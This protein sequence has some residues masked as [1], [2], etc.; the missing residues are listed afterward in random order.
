MFATLISLVI[1]PC[2]YLVLEDGK[3][4]LRRLYGRR[5]AGGAT[6]PAAGGSPTGAR[7]SPGGE[8]R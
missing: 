2:V 7:T 5:E 8:P 1:V 6:E 4:V 3:N